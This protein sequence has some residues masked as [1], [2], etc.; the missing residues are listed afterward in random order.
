MESERMSRITRMGHMAT[1]K[2]FVDMIGE[3]TSNTLTKLHELENDLH[4]IKEATDEVM[5]QLNNAI[6]EDCM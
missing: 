3:K 6:Y 5:L 2:E 4:T 1:A